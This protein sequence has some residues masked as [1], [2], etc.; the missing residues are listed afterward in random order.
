MLDAPLLIQVPTASSDNFSQALQIRFRPC[1]HQLVVI[2]GFAHEQWRE[3][4]RAL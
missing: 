3:A 1:N 2:A 4:P